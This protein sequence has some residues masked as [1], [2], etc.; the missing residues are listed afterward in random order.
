MIDSETFFD[1]ARLN[2][3]EGRERSEKEIMEGLF[4]GNVTCTS[5][6]LSHL[7]S[8]K[9]VKQLVAHQITPQTSEWSD[10]AELSYIF[11]RNLDILLNLNKRITNNLKSIE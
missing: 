8:E 10:L 2:K 9:H 5:M 6:E 4:G 7:L 11:E 1:M 3:K